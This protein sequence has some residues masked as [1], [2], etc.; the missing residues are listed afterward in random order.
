MKPQLY[1]NN[2]IIQELL[3]KLILINISINSSPNKEIKK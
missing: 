2:F 1:I 3:S